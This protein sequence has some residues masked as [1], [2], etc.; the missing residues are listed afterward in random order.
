[1][2]DVIIVDEEGRS[3]IGKAPTSPH[4]ESVGYMESFWEALEYMGIS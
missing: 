3:V 1:M 2:T 4:D